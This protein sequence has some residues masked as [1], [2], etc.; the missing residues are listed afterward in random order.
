M[1]ITVVYEALLLA[2]SIS[3]LF[4]FL[5]FPFSQF[6]PVRNSN[7][8]FLNRQR[9]AN[10]KMYITPSGS[11]AKLVY[12]I[13]WIL[14]ISI[15]RYRES[16]IAHRSR[17]TPFANVNLS[18]TPDFI[19]IIRDLSLDSLAGPELVTPSEFFSVRMIPR[20]T[21]PVKIL[22]TRKRTSNSTRA[23]PSFTVVLNR[24]GTEEHTQR[25]RARV[26]RDWSPH[27]R[28]KLRAR[29]PALSFPR[30]V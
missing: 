4:F 5:L 19:V 6:L 12:F 18:F 23:V 22:M 9:H 25:P 28:F 7:Y 26:A 8:N 17:S 3:R 14:S 2:L 24:R 10:N 30:R 15:S 1:I 16:R 11:I 27:P 29:A 13:P 20:Y 21:F